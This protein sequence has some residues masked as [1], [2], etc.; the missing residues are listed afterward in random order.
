MVSSDSFD[1]EY[2]PSKIDLDST[3]A[4]QSVCE[5]VNPESSSILSE[6]LSEL[7]PSS[8]PLQVRNDQQLTSNTNM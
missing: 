1:V 5:P 7:K 3:S 6:F 4:P 2:R 8:P